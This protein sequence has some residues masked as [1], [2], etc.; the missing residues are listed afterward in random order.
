MTSA[1]VV[2]M[3]DREAIGRGGALLAVAIVVIAGVLFAIAAA[4]AA[5]VDDSAMIQETKV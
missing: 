4:A 2:G 5:D 3:V 1:E